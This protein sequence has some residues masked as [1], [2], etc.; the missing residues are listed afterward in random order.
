M[1]GYV[2]MSIA[3]VYC[4][5]VNNHIIYCGVFMNWELAHFRMDCLDRSFQFWFVFI[6]SKRQ[7]FNAMNILVNLQPQPVWNV[8][9]GWNCL[10]RERT[11]WYQLRNEL[12]E[13]SEK[14]QSLWRYCR[15]R[16][17]HGYAMIAESILH[18]QSDRTSL[19]VTPDSVAATMKTII[20]MLKAS[21][22][23]CCSDKFTP[24]I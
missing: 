12:R 9:I 1:C 2:A 14:F 11:R 3:N 21:V 10:A 4:K 8:G 7:R 13:K 16:Q 17:A 24:Q 5:K 15:L 19:Q 18:A 20:I 6:G 23:S 22:Y